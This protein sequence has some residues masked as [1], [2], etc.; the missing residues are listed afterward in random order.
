MPDRRLENAS[1]PFRRV[2]ESAL[3]PA[4]KGFVSEHFSHLR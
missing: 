2:E 1:D 4:L 3:E